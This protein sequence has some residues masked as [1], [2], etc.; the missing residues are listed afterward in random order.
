MENK[1]LMQVLVILL[2]ALLL[3]TAVQASEKNCKHSWYNP[4]AGIW[5]AI[6]N[7]DKGVA[8]LDHKV[9]R[10]DRKIANLQSNG[11]A[12]PPGPKG[13]KGDPGPA[14]KAS[15]FICPG[16]N[17]SNSDEWAN[18]K[19]D[20]QLSISSKVTE[21]NAGLFAGAYLAHSYFDYGDFSGT[22]FSGA[23]LHHSTFYR[24]NFNN[25]DFTHANLKN[26]SF[27]GSDLTGADFSGANMDQVIW[28]DPIFEK[29]YKWNSTICPD[30]TPAEELGNSCAN[31]LLT[32]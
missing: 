22:D 2:V 1:R 29:Y 16:C 20:M 32:K 18:I 13:D 21:E 12:G 9:N 31:N 10:L 30:G 8:K 17:F 3:A 25:A 26:A 5:K 15:R 7:I 6:G 14:G 24:S 11:I 19:T 27:S 23:V 28:W 4:F